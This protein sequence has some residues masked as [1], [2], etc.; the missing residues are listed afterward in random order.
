M[1]NILILSIVFFLANEILHCQTSILNTEV[2]REER[3]LKI[4]S[5]IDN[6]KVR[7]VKSGN[8]NQNLGTL[9]NKELTYTFNTISGKQ[10]TL[11]LYGDHVETKKI[12]IYRYL[13]NSINPFSPESYAIAYKSRVLNV[14]MYYTKAYMEKE[15]LKIEQSN[16]PSVFENYIISFPLSLYKSLAVNKKDSLELNIAVGKRSEKAM[17]DYIS[18]HASSKFLKDAQKIKNDFAE[19]RTEFSRVKSLDNVLAYENFISKYPNSIEYN[20]AHVL[21]LN[22]A[23]KEALS[24]NNSEAS[25][26]YLEKYLQKFS[27]FLSKEELERKTSTIASTID[28][29]IVSENIDE[30]NKYESY[31]KLWK[32]YQDIISRQ[33]DIIGYFEQSESHREKISN[34]LFLS[35]SKLSNETAQSSFLKKAEIDFPRFNSWGDLGNTFLNAIL[36]QSNSLAGTIKL[37]NQNHIPN[38][39]KNNCGERCPLVGRSQYSYKGTYLD[40]FLGANYEELKYKDGSF[41]DIK[42]FKDKQLLAHFKFTKTGYISEANYYSNGKIVNSYFNE[43]NGNY[44]TYEYENGVNLSL[45]SLDAKISEA[46]KALATNDFDRALNILNNDCQNKFPKNTAQNQRIQNTIT[47]VNQSKEAYLKKQEEIRLAEERKREA[48]RL[49]E[50]KRQEEIR[51]SEE[52]KRQL[53]EEKLKSQYSKNICIRYEFIC[54]EEEKLSMSRGRYD[55]ILFLENGT[56]KLGNCNSFGDDVKINGYG[57]YTI[58]NN[59]INI[60]DNYGDEYYFK[61]EKTIFDSDN[62]CSLV[63]LLKKQDMINYKGNNMGGQIYKSPK[64]GGF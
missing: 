55:Y 1:K 33:P 60:K 29:Q 59:R 45:K 4:T 26:N 35:I 58:S 61:I 40:A 50:E 30:K 42:V 28:R 64:I 24:K 20:D 48:S 22:S 57:S 49:A 62:K 11:E 46:D 31:A 43:G 37:Y 17:D 44:Y 25:L 56:L 2:T 53:E 51:L 15:Y 10:T 7:F 9:T 54:Q 52:N 13:K 6:V 18:S 23:E 19:A 41:E 39:I 16:N 34:E 21:L 8:Y 63:A 5:N 27:S 32:K 47:K 3:T 36:T 14:E 38:F 12:K